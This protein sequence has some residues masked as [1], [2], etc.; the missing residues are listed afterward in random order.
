MIIVLVY[1][2]YLLIIEDSATMICEAKEVLDQKFKLK[3]LGE[4]NYFLGIRVL[5][6]TQGVI[7]N[8]SELIFETELAAA[9]PTHTSLE[10][11]VKLILVEFNQDAADVIGCAI[12]KDI[13]SHQRL[14]G[15]LMYAIIT[16]FDIHYVV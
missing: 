6:S 14:I 8:Q 11:N 4:L 2:D 3:Y 5:R 16:R 15:K 12:L 1:V 13:T 7:L 10:S 9:K